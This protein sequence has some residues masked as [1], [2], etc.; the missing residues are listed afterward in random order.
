MA[1]TI[2]RG[3]NTPKE[4]IESVKKELEVAKNAGE[5]LIKKNKELEEKL[6]TTEADIETKK[7]EIDNLKNKNK[8]LENKLKATEKNLTGQ[9]T[10]NEAKS[11]E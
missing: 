2:G 7:V 1:R 3:A 4:T 5:E 6:K 8:E 9:K 11:G 10:N